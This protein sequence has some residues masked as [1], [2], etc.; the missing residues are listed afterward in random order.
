MGAV[1]RFGDSRDVHE[2]RSDL[3]LNTEQAIKAGGVIGIANGGVGCAAP[4]IVGKPIEDRLVHDAARQEVGLRDLGIDAE[5]IVQR[6]R[7]TRSFIDVIV[8]TSSYIVR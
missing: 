5:L 1:V 6:C 3:G 7:D 8:E 2:V 4:G